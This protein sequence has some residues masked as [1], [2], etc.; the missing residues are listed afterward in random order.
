MK[1]SKYFDSSEVSC[2][3][4]KCC[5]GSYPMDRHF[6]KCLDG[7]RHGIGCPITITSGFR[8]LTHN[9]RI[10]GVESS[11]HTKGLACDCVPK[12][13]DLAKLHKVAKLYFEEVIIYNDKHF[14]H[15]ANPL[16]ISK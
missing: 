10:G 1:L 14:V 16:N 9:K 15:I 2:K 13:G 7:V 4:T 5:G 6:M 8:C 11:F 3:G 12:D